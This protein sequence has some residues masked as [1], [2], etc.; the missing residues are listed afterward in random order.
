[1]IQLVP[2][3]P[4][5][6][7]TARLQELVGRRTPWSRRLWSVG[8]ITALREALEAAE[9]FADGHS[10][11]KSLG[12]VIQG[13]R[14]AACADPGVGDA[15]FRDELRRVL[16]GGLG[17]QRERDRLAH[18]IDRS[19]SGYLERWA[20]AM[21]GAAPTELEA[22]A[23]SIASHMLDGGFSP[24]HLRA[25]LHATL[26]ETPTLADLLTAAQAQVL[27]DPHPYEILVPFSQLSLEAGMEL[28][29]GWL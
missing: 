1:M 16:D 17:E 22:A 23:R 15:A 29:H 11:Q 14:S 8:S 4:Y 7:M 10:R 9:L 2:P 3:T 13:A 18:M 21:P 20:A 6:Y 5:D 27:K 24:A 26:A 28:P 25:W 19:A 12:E